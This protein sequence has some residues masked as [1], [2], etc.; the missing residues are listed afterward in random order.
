MNYPVREQTIAGWIT[1]PDRHQDDRRC[2]A[3][4]GDPRALDDLRRAQS[5]GPI[6]MRLR[7]LQKRDTTKGRLRSLTIQR[8]AFGLDAP[9]TLIR[10]LGRRPKTFALLEAKPKQSPRRKS[11]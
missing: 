3:D 2:T 6:R 5:R 11:S 4:T 8:A 7:I 10:R 9:R 1:A